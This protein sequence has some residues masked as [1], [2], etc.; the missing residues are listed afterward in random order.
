MPTE[1]QGQDAVGSRSGRGANAIPWRRNLWAMWAAQMLAIV[2]FSLRVPYL[3]FFLGDLGV[4]TT[5]G[6]AL[7]SGIINA[8]GAGIMAISAPFWGAVSDRY[9]R[10][11]MLLRAQFAAVFTIGLMAFATAAWHLLALRLLEGALAGTVTAATALVASTTPKERLGFSLGM[12]QTAVFSGAALGPLAGGVLA[13]QIGYRPT[14]LVSSAMML[15]AGLITIFFVGE[16][17]TRAPRASG[18]GAK[19]SRRERWQVLL[20]PVLLAMTAVMFAVRLASSAVQPIMPLFVA[21]LTDAASNSASLAGVTLGVLGLTSAVSSL[22]FGRLGDRRGHR[23][24]LIGCAL[25]AGLLYLPMALTQHPWQLVVLQALFGVAAGG[26]IPA[27]NA[28]VATVTAPE[29]RGV[30]YGLMA[31]AASLG[32]FIGPLAGSALAASLGFRATFV[33]TALVLLALA[34][35]LLSLGRRVDARTA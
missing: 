7:W 19:G 26:M 2:A 16:R 15:G 17:F 33:A 12:I 18:P 8:A 13:E 35:L 22:Y 11:P 6:Q 4:T 28:I 5:E 30:V 9:G 3:P 23:P 1:A 25:A 24:I 32:G 21:E 31:A 27:A 10:K 14:F 20:T 29:R 34:G